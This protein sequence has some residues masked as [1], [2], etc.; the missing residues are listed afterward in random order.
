MI[1]DREEQL[2]YF[3]SRLNSIGLIR[4]DNLHKPV[5]IDHYTVLVSLF[6]KNVFS[7][8]ILFRL[9]RWAIIVMINVKRFGYR[10][11]NVLFCVSFCFVSVR[12]LPCSCLNSHCKASYYESHRQIINHYSRISKYRLDE[13]SKQEIFFNNFVLFTYS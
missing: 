2:K 5:L 6:E 12:C 13:Q 11:L 8:L 4:M 10:R 9:S 7:S 1:D 3:L